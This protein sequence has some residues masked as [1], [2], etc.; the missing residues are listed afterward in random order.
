M[1]STIIK[2]YITPSGSTLDAIDRISQSG[3]AS[4]STLELQVIENQNFLSID[5][6]YNSEESPSN[7]KEKSPSDSKSTRNEENHQNIF[8]IT[9][10]PKWFDRILDGIFSSTLP[11]S[12]ENCTENKKTVSDTSDKEPN[13]V[14]NDTLS[15][16]LSMQSSE[17][18]AKQ[19]T[20]DS[21]S[22]ATSSEHENLDNEIK[23]GENLS[24]TTSMRPRKEEPSAYS[25]N[26]NRYPLN[27]PEIKM[28]PEWLD[29][30]LDW[31][32]SSTLPKTDV[33]MGPGVNNFSP[34]CSFC[35]CSNCFYQVYS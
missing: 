16:H 2:G 32:L 5:T 25:N 26:F 28:F 29:K 13:S 30:T 8:S 17:D 27:L 4:R 34:V 12:S 19:S 31:L 9:I 14:N 21:I 1:P 11:G 23:T 18:G 22:P 6:L 3:T 7:T 15:T 33:E 10:L 20:S 24:T 35:P